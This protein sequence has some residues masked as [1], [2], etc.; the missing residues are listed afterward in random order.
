MSSTGSKQTE[1]NALNNMLRQVGIDD[2]GAFVNQ[3]RNKVNQENE[4]SNAGA[5][6]QQPDFVSMG[7][8][9]FNQVIWFQIE[10]DQKQNTIL[11]LV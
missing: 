3:F 1:S 6:Q 11:Y 8:S 2:V 9:L 4:K 5:Q 10:I 7:T